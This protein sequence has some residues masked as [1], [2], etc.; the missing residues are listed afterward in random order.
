MVGHEIVG[1]V[2]CVGSQAAGNL[3]IGDLVAVGAQGD[4]CLERDGPCEPCHK[5]RENYCPGQVGTYAAVHRNGDKSFGGYALYHRTASHFVF[6]VPQG[7]NPDVVA[8]MLCAGATVYDPIKEYGVGPGKKIGVVG[9]GGLGHFAILFSKALGAEVVAI[10]RKAGKKMDS[11][12]MGA[13][14]FIATEEDEEWVAKN[15][16]SLDL[17]MSTSSNAKVRN[18][19]LIRFSHVD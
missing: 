13:D 7:M 1:E 17:I 16:G 12:K 9:I 6:K 14:E 4:A 2:V 19:P 8:P 15:A 10:S 5:H 3:Q 18:I 11:L